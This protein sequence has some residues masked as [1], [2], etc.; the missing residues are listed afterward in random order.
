MAP[1]RLVDRALAHEP[2]LAALGAEDAVRVL[3]A[4]GERRGLQPGLLSRARLHH[5]D[6]EAAVLSP[7]F[8]HPQKHLGEV[9]RVGAADVGLQG[10]DGVACV[11]LAGEKG[12]FLQ[13]VEL[14][15]ER[16]DRLGDLRVHAAVHRVQLACV[17]VLADQLLVA[18]E[19]AL[20]A[21]MLCRDIRR[22]LLV[23]P[24]ARRAHLP[25]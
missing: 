22:S 7:A 15:L 17:L 10:D 21:R 23:V 20:H 13:P 19:L 2:V 5:V 16:R 14:L 25:F 24:E 1:V 8:V 4:E 11:V 6:L 9:L 12:L 3:A 18:F